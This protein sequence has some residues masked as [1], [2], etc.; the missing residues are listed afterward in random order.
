MKTIKLTPK[1]K[2]LISMYGGRFPLVRDRKKE[3]VIEL[4]KA[5]RQLPR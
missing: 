4:G 3:A 2:N 1:Q 5:M